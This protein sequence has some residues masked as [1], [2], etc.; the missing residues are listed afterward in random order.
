MRLPMINTVID[1]HVHTFPEKIAASALE[2]LQ[3]KSH[4]RPFTDGTLN[5][6]KLSMKEAGVS[7]SVLQPVATKPEQVRGIN[8]KAVKIN[9]SSKNII[10]FGAMHPYFENYEP[11]LERIFL[12]GI[13]GIKIHP[14]YQNLSIDDGK[15]IKILQK[16]CSLGLAVL[17]HAGWDIGFPGNDY[18][19][20]EKIKK[21]LEKINGAEKIILAHMGGW[22]AWDEAKKIFADHDGV[23]IDTA[24]ALGEFTPNGDNF[25]KTREDCKMLEEDKFTEIIKTFG[26]ERVVF[27]SDSPWASQKDSVEKINSLKFLDTREKNLILSK[28]AERFFD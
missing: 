22:R 2:K 17:I 9:F 13:K 20:P 19:M 12:A 15:Y 3:A 18:A 24:F 14:V 5:G 8:D 1:F 4:T 16:A 25:Y 7:C 21:V 11:E 28:N 6:L 23:F 10:S 26:A 27:G